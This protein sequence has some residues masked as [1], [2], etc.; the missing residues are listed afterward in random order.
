MLKTA[1]RARL[2]RWGA[3][4]LGLLLSLPLLPLQDTSLLGKSEMPDY[5]LRLEP[6]WLSAVA[7]DDPSPPSRVAAPLETV[8]YNLHS[9]LGPRLARSAGADQVRRRLRGIAAE[10]AG[11]GA[12]D[13]IG[14]NEVDFGSRRS[15]WIDQA[16]FL[17]AELETLTGYTYSVVGGPTWSRETAG[18]EVRFGNAMLT[19]HPVL[20]S[21]NCL[22]SALGE[23]ARASYRH[24]PAAGSPGLLSA[25]TEPRGV[26]R[27]M[28]AVE[29]RPVD[30]LVT[31]LEAFAVAQRERQAS[32]LLKGVV[33]PERTTVLLGDINAVPTTLTAGR[34]YFAADRT[35]DL[36][37]SGPLADARVLRA[38]ILARR[39][40]GAWATYPAEAPRWPLDAVFASTDLWPER[41]AAIGGKG[42]SDHRGLYARYR[43]IGADPAASILHARIKRNQA[44]RLQA[45]DGA[46]TPR[47]WAA[48]VGEGPGRQP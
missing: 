2:L 6:P 46:D 31:H 34:W 35:H 5:C 21:S 9:G 36:L 17:A 10:I 27:A 20:E 13:V 37:N 30:V 11:T 38:A 39:D 41:I 43:W 40:L 19:R 33:R 18:A 14:L 22:Y 29:G 26:I 3:L 25:F 45:C 24:R 44:A 47:L 7:P 15:A 16:A 28:V 42:H 12:A 8:V 4:P 1:R 48:A 23:C 32:A